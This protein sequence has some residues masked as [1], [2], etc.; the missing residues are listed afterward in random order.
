M[1]SKKMVAALN[2]QI[3]KE[4]FS[5]YL[6]QEIANY[7]TDQNLNGFGHWFGVQVQEEMAHA[8]LFIKYLQAHNAKVTLTAIEDPTTEF[9]DFGAPLK[10]TLEHEQSITAAI[11]E[12]YALAVKDKDYMTQN[13]LQ[14]FISEQFE[15]EQN[16]NDLI[17][18]YELF[19]ADLKALYSMNV[20]LGTRVFAPPSLKF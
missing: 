7:Y 14:W 8:G 13:M 6:Y 16:A 20:D 5:A 15:E 12:L 11:H 17:A 9:A 18:R 3:N 1:L 10:L 19:G 2:E 4:L